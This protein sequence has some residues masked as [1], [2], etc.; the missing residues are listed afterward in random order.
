M[1]N[2]L[3][4]ILPAHNEAGNVERVVSSLMKAMTSTGWDFLILIVNDGSQD[5]TGQICENLSRTHPCIRCVHHDR[6]RGYG[7]ALISGFKSAEG[8]HVGIMDGD[9]QFDAGDLV[10]LISYAGSFDVVVGYRR[11]R[12]DPSG[13]RIMGQTWTLIGRVL[14]D[15]PVRDLNCGLKIFRR[16]IMDGLTLRC[17]GP[18]INLEIM[19]QI[20]AAGIRIKEVDCSHYPRTIG[21]QSGGSLR[22][23]KKAI[24]ELVSVFRE[25]FR[26]T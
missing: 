4:I 22:A 21:N 17:V 18:G 1:S 8:T 14:F 10:R 11:R 24:P 5:Q 6:N 9:D 15:I 19:A 7:G 13:R 16:S 2:K 23:I 3:T 12:A 25:R 26:K 20:A